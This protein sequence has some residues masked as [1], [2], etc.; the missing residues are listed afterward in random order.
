M[1]LSPPETRASLILRLSDAADIAAWD[2]VVAVY[3][4]LLYRIARRKALQP[5]DADDLVQEV[6][7]AVA[8]SVEQW[9]QRPDRGRFRAWL[10][11]IARNAAINFLTRPKY[12]PLSAGGS[13][14]GNT[15]AT[16]AAP[17]ISE[18]FDFEYRREAFRWASRQVRETVAA[19][20]WEAFW[21]TTME[22]RPIAEVAKELK[23]TPGSIY[24]ARC[25]IMTKLRE[26]V[27]QLEERER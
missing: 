10:M 3:G 24:I 5:H 21:L 9:L 7:T 22:D 8:G 2:E 20:T 17:D 12:R 26:L 6:L 4:P 11:C 19:N 15:L 27:R 25:R 23:M 13:A 16:L 18:E 1:T 14:A